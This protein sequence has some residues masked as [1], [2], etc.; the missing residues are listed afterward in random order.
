LGVV[1][2]LLAAGFVASGIIG[3]PEVRKL[4]H[5]VHLLTSSHGRAGVLCKVL[6][7]LFLVLAREEAAE[8][9]ETHVLQLCERYAF[10]ARPL[11]CVRGQCVAV[12]ARRLKHLRQERAHVAHRVRARGAGRRS[13]S[14][15]GPSLRGQ[16]GG[17][18]K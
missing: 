14:A 8:L 16:G 5:G 13:R 12:D 7:G 2:V 11:R 4:H 18:H 15:T 9:G 17:K 6:A 3:I 1:A 10:A